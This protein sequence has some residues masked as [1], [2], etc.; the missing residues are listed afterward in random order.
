ME[1]RNTRTLA[2]IANHMDKIIY[3]QLSYK[4]QGVLFNIQ[5]QLGGNYREKY[6]HRAIE[7]LF[8]HEKI[9]FKRELPVNISITEGKIGHHFLDFLIEDKII[10]EIKQGRKPSYSDVR[11]VLMYLKSTGKKLGIIAA[12]HSS[13]VTVKRIVNPEVN[14]VE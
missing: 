9:S 4:V 11:Q 2:D 6:Y 10:L 5:K 3:R 7:K 8:L 13:E 14:A 12:F 1:S